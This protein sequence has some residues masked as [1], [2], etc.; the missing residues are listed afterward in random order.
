[1][2]DD[3]IDQL[4]AALPAPDLDEALARRVLAAAKAELAADRAPPLQL[5]P[6]LRGALV[7]ALLSAAA[8]G[9]TAL[10][11]EAAAKIYGSD[12]DAKR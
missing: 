9:R 7:P 11:V 8:V 5:G 10:T 4:L 12:R 2:N 6:A 3:A 1:M